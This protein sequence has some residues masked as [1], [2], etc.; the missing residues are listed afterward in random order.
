MGIIGL[1]L[2][3]GRTRLRC[4]VCTTIVDEDRPSRRVGDHVDTRLFYKRNEASVI[5]AD[6][7]VRFKF[8]SSAGVKDRKFDRNQYFLSTLLFRKD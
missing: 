7:E 6:R 2:L 8:P 1:L 3:F 4:I 5:M